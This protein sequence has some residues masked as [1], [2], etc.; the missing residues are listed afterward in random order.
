[1]RFTAFQ[2][3]I[4]SG[5]DL[6][7]LVSIESASSKMTTIIG[8]ANQ[9]TWRESAWG[10]LRWADTLMV[11]GSMISF[12]GSSSTVSGKHVIDPSIFQFTHAPE[13]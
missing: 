10:A 11:S 6:P 2:N 5:C 4:E 13:R 7:L 12:E 8:S 9:P 1:M 3:P